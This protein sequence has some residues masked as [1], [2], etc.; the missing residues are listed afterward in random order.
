MPIWHESSSCT[1]LV[2]FVIIDPLRDAKALDNNT[3][4]LSAVTFSFGQ[5]IHG[6]GFIL[7]GRSL[8]SIGGPKSAIFL[9]LASLTIQGLCPEVSTWTSQ[10]L[11]DR[12][13]ISRSGISACHVIEISGIGIFDARFDE[14]AIDIESILKYSLFSG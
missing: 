8:G 11:W 5:H 10:S 9:V 3:R 4:L 6:M 1:G 12:A 7:E 14:S 13:R 2:D